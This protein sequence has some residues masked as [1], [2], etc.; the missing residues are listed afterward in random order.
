MT[1]EM[2]TALSPIIDGGW[3]RAILLYAP[4]S[5]AFRDH[6]SSDA[7][8]SRATSCRALL[9]QMV[10]NFNTIEDF[11]TWIETVLHSLPWADKIGTSQ[12]G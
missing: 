7:A 5:E 3:Q 2:F 9:R 4:D 6:I 10:A 1:R 8:Q 11:A 12:S